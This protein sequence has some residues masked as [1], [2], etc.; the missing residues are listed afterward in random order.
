MATVKEYGV[1]AGMVSAQVVFATTLLLSR[2]LFTHGM[3][4]YAFVLYRQMTSTLVI[5][6]I[7]FYINR[8]TLN[9]M[10]HNAGTALTSSI[11][12]GTMNNLIPS[13]TFLLAY[14]LR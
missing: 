4:F 10:L 11:F 14:L 8:V 2:H 7:F 5:S 6:P 12:V 3:S 1:A 9:Q 13:I